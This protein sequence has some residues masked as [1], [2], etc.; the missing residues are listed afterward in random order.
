[1]PG[2]WRAL[3]RKPADPTRRG[4]AIDVTSGSLRVTAKPPIFANVRSD[5]RPEVAK[6]VPSTRA[7][8]S[9]AE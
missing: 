5:E 4:G 1:M 8:E 6:V 3:R 9:R 7:R 2:A